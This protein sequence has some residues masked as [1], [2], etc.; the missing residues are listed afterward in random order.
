MK[1]PMKNARVKGDPK[2][3]FKTLKRLLGYTFG[4]KKALAV[5]IVVC[6][7]LSAV[8]NI[9]GTY[10]IK[11]FI[12]D[13]IT[14]L[15]GQQTPDL[16]PFSRALLLMAAVYAVSVATSYAYNRLM[17]NVSKDAL[18]R[19]RDDMF[20]KMQKLP[21]SFFDTHLHGE[22]MSYYTN[23]IEAIRQMISNSLPQMISSIFMV[24]GVFTAMVILSWQLTIVVLVILALMLFTVTQIGG[25]AGKYFVRQ[26]ESTSKLNG[27]IEEM[28]N[29][30]KVVK[31][32]NRENKVGEEFDSFNNNLLNVSTKANVYAS[33]LMPI[34]GN[35]GYIMYIVSALGGAFMAINGIGNLGLGS[36]VVFAQYCRSF[37][38]PI[39]QM[40]Q[41]VNSIA[42]ALAGASRVFSLLDQ[43]PEENDGKVTL[44]NTV[45]Q[46]GQI[47]ESIERTGEWAWK[48]VLD[49]NI[50]YT[51]L[52]GDIRFDNV[53]FGYKENEPVLHGIS[54]S[55]EAGKRLA[56]VG[57]TGAGKTTITNL[58]NRFYDIQSGTITYDGIDIRNINKKDLRRSLGA[59]LQDTHLFTGTILE[60]IRFGRL[61]ATDDEVI[62][63]AKLAN[64]DFFITHLPEG[65]NTV[66]KSD[67]DNLSQG[68][69]QLISIARAAV[70]DPPVLVM[71]EATSNIDTRTEGLIISGMEQLM[72]GRTVFVIAHRLSTVRNAHTIIVLDHGRIIEQGSH[73]ELIRQKGRYYQLYTGAFELE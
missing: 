69:R 73:E 23:D 65:Y 60:N 42:M 30:Q 47:T 15:I 9:A 51:P 18:K 14:P 6:I 59:V 58:I 24:T 48:Q 10:F 17:I 67:G 20:V 34:M 31:V 52:K 26:Q 39:S 62:A 46:N 72:E 43:T 7:I 4:K 50:V 29:G 53:V 11:V 70:A 68:Q 44:V 61:D 13:Y 36:I 55:A 12:D 8:T 3:D 66:I 1:G 33:V 56:F 54:L 64:A 37:A 35:L 71:D 41:E 27:Y 22:V 2:Q 38:S 5:V 25:R 19:M 45:S 49:D 63:A 28:I 57:A 16:V 32:F 21:L 40:S